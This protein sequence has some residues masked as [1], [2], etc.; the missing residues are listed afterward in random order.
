VVVAVRERLWSAA[1]D[2]IPGDDKDKDLLLVC[3]YLCS[4]K[5]LPGERDVMI[6]VR[7]ARGEPNN[8]PND[9]A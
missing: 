4:L 7:A 1:K 5:K 3:Q 6:E 9:T 8:G 2:L